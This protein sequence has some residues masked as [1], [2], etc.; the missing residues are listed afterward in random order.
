MQTRSP[1]ALVLAG[2][3]AMGAF[4]GGA[5]EALDE[6]GL[7]DELTWLAGSSIGSVAAAILAGNAPEDRVSRLR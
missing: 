3:I 6:T 4:E 1:F 2:G 5:Y 7:A